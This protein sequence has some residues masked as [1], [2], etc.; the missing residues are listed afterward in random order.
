MPVGGWGNL[1]IGNW[2]FGFRI[3]DLLGYGANPK[4]EIPIPKFL[5]IP[6]IWREGWGGAIIMGRPLPLLPYSVCPWPPREVVLLGPP[7]TFL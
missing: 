1:G 3:S 7:N 4:S 6:G 5:Y 2:D